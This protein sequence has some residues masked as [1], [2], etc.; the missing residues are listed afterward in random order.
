[1]F[2]HIFFSLW[3]TP[4]LHSCLCFLAEPLKTLLK[5]SVFIQ[6]NHEFLLQVLDFLLGCF[7]GILGPWYFVFHRLPMCLKGTRSVLGGVPTSAQDSKYERAHFY[8]LFQGSLTCWVMTCWGFYEMP[9][10]TGFE[11]WEYWP[12]QWVT[13]GLQGLRP[14]V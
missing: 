4:S 9:P 5:M 12:P 3:D 14:S 2:Q 6:P 7:Q 11:I 8:N 13:G 1:M 10:S